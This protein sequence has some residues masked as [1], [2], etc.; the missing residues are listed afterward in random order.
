MSAILSLAVLV[1]AVVLDILQKWRRDD[2]AW[3]AAFRRA[4]PEACPLC[5]YHRMGIHHGDVEPSPV[6]THPNCPERHRPR[7]LRGGA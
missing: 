5:S 6:P 7:V 1:L 3:L 2:E 4:F